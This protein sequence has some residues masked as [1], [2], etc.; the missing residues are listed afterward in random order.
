MEERHTEAKST[1]KTAR[2]TRAYRVKSASMRSFEFR[3]TGMATMRW[4]SCSTAWVAV[5][6]LLPGFQPL[7]AQTEPALPVPAFVE[8]HRQV[9]GQDR[10]T[11]CVRDTGA[12]ATDRKR[13][14]M[15]AMATATRAANAAVLDGRE[16]VRDATYQREVVR[17]ATGSNQGAVEERWGRVVIDGQAS[18]CVEASLRP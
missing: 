10:W 7:R 1:G 12:E 16:R 3:W 2:W 11:R 4:G 9:D 15:L 17:T 8:G 5:A 18:V 14:L 6:L 13:A